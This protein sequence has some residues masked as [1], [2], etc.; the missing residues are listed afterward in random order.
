VAGS[1]VGALG[2]ASVLAVLLSPVLADA[3]MDSTSFATAVA[4]LNPLFDLLLVAAVV[5]IAAFG[6]YGWAD[7]GASWS[8][9]C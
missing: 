3:A 5:G 2:A 8:R 6:E 9:A 4:I 1:A 7:G